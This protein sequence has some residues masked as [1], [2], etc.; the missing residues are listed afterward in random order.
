MEAGKSL[1]V[2]TDQQN[3]IRDYLLGRLPE[4]ELAALDEQAVVNS[5]FYEEL[6]IAEDELVDEYLDEELTPSERESFEKYFLIAPERHQ[7]LIFSKDLKNYLEQNQENAVPE[8]E[9]QPAP[10]DNPK[11][12]G[13]PPKPPWYHT[14]LPIRTPALAYAVMALIMLTFAGGLY[15]ILKRNRPVDT[16]PVYTMVLTTGLTRGEGTDKKFSLPPGSGTVELRPQLSGDAYQSYEA[17]LLADDN[18]EIKRADNLPA[19]DDNGVRMLKWR[20]PARLVPPGDY[21]LKING[22]TD[23]GQLE[24]LRTYRFRIVR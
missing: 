4:D 16:S 20:L 24:A 13:P 8:P 6:L 18:S 23:H 17:V 5:E 12:K 9:P 7:K 19:T 2:N 11:V 21:S 14:F 10:D 22:K 1:N 15:E 3:T